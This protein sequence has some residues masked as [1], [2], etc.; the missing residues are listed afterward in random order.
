MLSR[1]IKIFP[2]T[3]GDLGRTKDPS[4]KTATAP[5]ASKINQG[6]VYVFSNI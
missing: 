6:E 3:S 4:E 2:A 1:S 5:I